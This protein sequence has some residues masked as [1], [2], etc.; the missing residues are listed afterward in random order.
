MCAASFVLPNENPKVNVNFVISMIK[1]IKNT[2][3]LC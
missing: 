1:L 3:S 2:C